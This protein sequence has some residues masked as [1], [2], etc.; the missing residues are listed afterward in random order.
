[1]T[2]GLRWHPYQALFSVT[3]LMHRRALVFRAPRL[4]DLAMALGLVTVVGVLILAA[5]ISLTAWGAHR[6]GRG[7][8]VS[9]ASGLGFPFAWAA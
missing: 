1:M 2:A 3:A 9:I 8:L 5:P 4:H 6:R 7:H